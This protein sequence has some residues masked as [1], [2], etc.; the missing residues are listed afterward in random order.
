MA[1]IKLYDPFREIERF[2]ED[3]FPGFFAPVRRHFAPAMDVYQTDKD[4]VVELQ[5]PKLDP[6]KLNVTVEKGILKI[7]AGYEEEKKDEGKEYFH[8]EI[9]RGGFARMVAL[10]VP[11]KED[12]ADASY[13]NGVLKVTLPK[14]EAKEAKKIEVK[15]K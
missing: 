3:D 13:E 10:P 5:V 8:R 4:V 15:I 1:N 2:F 6:S 14:V 9:R 12:Q 11:V 7:E